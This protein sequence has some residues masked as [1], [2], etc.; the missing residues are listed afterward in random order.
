MPQVT[1]IHSPRKPVHKIAIVVSRLGFVDSV[2]LDWCPGDRQRKHVIQF[3]YLCRHTHGACTLHM[4]NS[5]MESLAPE[6]CM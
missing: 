4:S 3:D 6:P 2:L 1:Q 5:T